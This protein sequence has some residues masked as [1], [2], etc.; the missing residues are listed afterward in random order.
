MVIDDITRISHML[1]EAQAAVSF[2]KDMSFEEFCNDRKTVN[3]TVRSIEVIGEAAS[4]LSKTFQEKHKNIDWRD[5]LS[6][7]NVL[8]HAYFEIDHEIIWKTVQGDLPL[9]IIT[10][11]EIQ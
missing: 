11:K 5:V 9:F 2:C 3:A 6:M 10:L 8:A 1:E 7:R 4:K